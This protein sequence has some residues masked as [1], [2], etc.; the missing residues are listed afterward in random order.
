[1]RLCS[2][3]HIKTACV[4]VQHIL[5][6]C[7]TY[8]VNSALS[9]SMQRCSSN[10]SRSQTVGFVVVE[11]AR[12]ARAKS[13]MAA[14]PS[15]TTHTNT[16]IYSGCATQI[17]THTDTPSVCMWS[18][19][20]QNSE[21]SLSTLLRARITADFHAKPT[22]ARARNRFNALE[23]NECSLRNVYCI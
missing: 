12:R 10:S 17:Y 15:V 5:D 23:W 2:C 18:R 7:H 6:T 9:D 20:L 16:D 14:L 21:R 22:R 4:A 11:C 8:T 1:M 3:A 19:A 13:H